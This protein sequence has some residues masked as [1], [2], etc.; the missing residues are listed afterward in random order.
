MPKLSKTAR[1]SGATGKVKSRGPQRTNQKYQTRRRA[2]KARCRVCRR[3]VKH[4]LEETHC[5]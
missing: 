4:G 1:A 2:Q 5:R 3:V